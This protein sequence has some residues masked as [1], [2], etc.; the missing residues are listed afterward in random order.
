VTDPRVGFSS[1]TAIRRAVV[2][3]APFRP[4]SPVI[5]PGSQEKLSSS[6]AGL[7]PYDLEMLSN[8]MAKFEPPLSLNALA[9]PSELCSRQSQ[10]AGLGFANT[11]MTAS[12]I[13]AKTNMFF[14]FVNAP[15]IL[16]NSNAMG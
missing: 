16:G 2:F 8:V 1:P 3:P 13:T 14:P 7:E 4:S 9:P 12:T 15:R 6:R 11:K 10:C 5:S